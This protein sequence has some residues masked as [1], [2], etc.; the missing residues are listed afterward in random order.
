M[1][2]TK[3]LHMYPLISSDGEIINPFHRNQVPG[4]AKYK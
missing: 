1:Y 4:L 3:D 2:S